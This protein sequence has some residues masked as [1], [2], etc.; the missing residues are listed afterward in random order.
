MATTSTIKLAAK[1]AV[2]AIWLAGATC[3]TAE[4]RGPGK[5]RADEV[6]R[7]GAP[8][9]LRVRLLAGNLPIVVGSI[10]GRPGINIMVD[11]GTSPAVLDARLAK[12]LGLELVPG[13][14]QGLGGTISTPGVWIPDVAVG[15]IHQ[16]KVPGLVRD[17][18]HLKN[19]FGVSVGAIVGLDFF[20]EA[21]FR[22]DYENRT[23]TFGAICAAGVA[24]PMNEESPF[25]V[26][27]VEVEKKRLRLLVDTG[28]SA[29]VLFRERVDPEMERLVMKQRAGVEGVAGRVSAVGN[30][31]WQSLEVIVHGRARRAQNVFL[32]SNAGEF[33]EFDGLMAVHSLGFRALA[34]DHETRTLYLQ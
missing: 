17:L 7:T 31:P 8:D 13:K 2:I 32:V 33:Q 1:M 15:P 23:L 5:A 9:E 27:N 20:E 29:T 12:S 16:R 19:R 28:A 6:C 26:V 21:S 3:A 30:V 4:G 25:A 10:G 34:Y 14:L 24:I 22:L 11:T 18:S